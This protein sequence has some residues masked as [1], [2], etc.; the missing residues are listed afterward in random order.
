M[1][2]LVP[3]SITTT[4]GSPPALYSLSSRMLTLPTRSRALGSSIDSARFLS[5]SRL[6]LLPTLS[7]PSIVPRVL[8]ILVSSRVSIPAI[9]GTPLSAN[10]SE[11]D[12]RDDQCEGDSN[13]EIDRKST[14]L[15]SSHVKISYAVF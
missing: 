14:R 10:H 1:P 6:E 4:L 8:I 12:S 11:R 5:C 13:S 2:S 15:N 3:Q 9:P 7:C